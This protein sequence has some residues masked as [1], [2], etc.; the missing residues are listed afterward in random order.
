MVRCASSRIEYQ[1]DI[2]LPAG[3]RE[4]DKRYPVFYLLDANLH[5]PTAVQAYRCQRIEGTVPELIVVGI[6]Y[7]EEGA[8]IATPAYQMHRA[9]DYTPTPLNHR[10]TQEEFQLAMPETGK[11]REFLEFL[12][13]QLIPLLDARYRTDP[14]SRALGGHSLGGLFTTHVLLNDPTVFSQYWLGSPSLWFNDGEPFTWLASATKQAIQPSGRAFLSVGALEGSF[15]VDSGRRMA[16][17]LTDSFGSLETVIRVFD[18]QTHMSVLGAS[19][20][21][22]LRALYAKKPRP[23][24]AQAAGEYVGRWRAAHGETMP[25][26]L[27]GER[28]I[29]SLAASNGVQMDVELLAESDDR[30][31]FKHYEYQD[32]VCERDASGRVVGMSRTLFGQHAKFK[33]D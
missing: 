3:Y 7:R 1:I 16:G 29:A 2:A 19:I 9:R 26:R 30:L 32:I 14:G 6:G 17:L 13:T 22:A 4:C 21:D 11:G 31:F 33:R 10:P 28:L 5:F 23:L 20:N 27:D 8:A 25:I 12:K 24:T 15:M 18:D